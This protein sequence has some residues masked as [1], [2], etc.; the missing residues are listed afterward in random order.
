MPG[1][2]TQYVL[3][4]AAEAPDHAAVR[5]RDSAW[6]YRELDRWSNRLARVLVKLGV[7]RGDR[8]ALWAPKSC[9]AVAVLQAALRSGAV[10]VPID[11]GTPPLRAVKIFDDCDVRLVVTTK[12]MGASLPPGRRLYCLDEE[13]EGEL[14]AAESDGP[15]E[16][17]GGSN[18]DLAFILYTSGST[19][20]PKGVCISHR[21]AGSFVEWATAAV[22]ISGPAVFANHA[23]FNFDLSVF[24]LYGA[25]L[26]RGS[27]CLIPETIAYSAPRLVEFLR[28]N[29]ISVW[30]SVPSV[31]MLM[32]DHGG[33]LDVSPP[34]PIVIFAGE[35]FPIGPLRKLRR[36]WPGTRMFNFYGPTETNVCTSYEVREIPDDRGTPVPIGT[37]AS[38]DRVWAVQEDGAVAQEGQTGEL[39]VE[40]P[41][42]MQG[43]WGR[44]PQTG[45]YR[46]GDFCRLLPDGSY[47][48]LGR[49]DHRVKVRGHRIEL[50]EIE[51]V[52][53]QHPNVKEVVVLPAGQAPDQR[54]VGYVVP[55]QP[56][57]PTLI[58]LKTYGAASLPRYMLLDRLFLKEALPRTPN[59]KIDRQALS[60][61]GLGGPE[62]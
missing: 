35:S 58:E 20:T 39:W 13:R 7:S 41:T 51:A 5:D 42:V 43:Y 6:T 30:Y 32:M 44:E 1:R 8:V 45:P 2:L 9:R 17:L 33:L 49:R 48:F 57:P 24:D 46:T 34:P 22:G 26:T 15:L 59:G 19:G 37:A 60:G 56:P 54:L 4:A 3:S 40:G 38:G 62:R 21:N 14:A 16:A 50:G 23:P 61:E 28:A 55:R 18:E 52:L 36:R 53:G 25:F 27:V 29:R 12:S 31:L 11:P 47:E 10:Y